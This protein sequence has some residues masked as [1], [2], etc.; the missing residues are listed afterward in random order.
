MGPRTGFIVL[1]IIN[2]SFAKEKIDHLFDIDKSNNLL[3]H[4]KDVD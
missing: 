2:C 3:L 4:K 1:V